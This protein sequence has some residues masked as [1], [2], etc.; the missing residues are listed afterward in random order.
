LSR[1]QNI[2]TESRVVPKRHGTKLYGWY[3]TRTANRRIQ[4]ASTL[5]LVLGQAETKW[6]FK[7]VPAVLCGNGLPGKSRP[8]MAGAELF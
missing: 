1:R 6:T 4:R 5:N 8:S 7:V 2:S 3:D